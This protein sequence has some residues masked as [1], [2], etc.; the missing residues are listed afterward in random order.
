[1]PGLPDR[2]EDC[3]AVKEDHR[4]VHTAECALAMATVFGSPLVIHRGRMVSY[5]IDSDDEELT[6]WVTWCPWPRPPESLF[7]D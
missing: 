3:G 7:D 5:E 6:K 2:C 4:I 1:M